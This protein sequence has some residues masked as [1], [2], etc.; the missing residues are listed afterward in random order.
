MDRAAI[1]S[2]VE[3]LSLEDRLELVQAIW[4]G[5]VEDPDRLELRED[6]KQELD[7]RLEAHLA[8]PDDVVPWDEVK[9]RIRGRAGR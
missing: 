5:I 3:T 9:G 6:Q 2:E 1:L 7:R 8:A 4:D